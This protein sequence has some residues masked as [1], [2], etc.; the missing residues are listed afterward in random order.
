MVTQNQVDLWLNDPVTRALEAALQ[1]GIEHLE[2]D[3]LVF[4]PDLHD[5]TYS[6][7]I[8]V[9]NDTNREVFRSMSDLDGFLKHWGVINDDN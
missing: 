7:S 6:H 1:K 3:L 9:R 8:I 5:A 2:W 4:N